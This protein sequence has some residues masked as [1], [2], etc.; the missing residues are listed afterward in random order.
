MDV[1]MLDRA[2][3]HTGGIV[4]RISRDDLGS[5]T[6]CA[7]WSVRDLLNHLIGSYEM[8]AAGASGETVDV[9]GTDYTSEDHAAAYDAAGARMVEAMSA[10]G[11]M[12]RKFKMPWG[13]TPG[14][15]LL[16][17]MVADAAVHGWDLAQATGQGAN[18]EPDIAEA[19]YETTSGM[20]EPKGSFPR[21]DSFAPPVDVPDD[22]PAEDRMVAYL[23]RQ[24][25]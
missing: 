24:P 19:V 8:V 16:G 20:M 23:G 9:A 11:A 10:E 22:A 2:V 1:G 4:A 3:R 5:S 18:V 17:L 6:P 15:V 25:S 12:E 7:E 21:G 14:Q 13:E